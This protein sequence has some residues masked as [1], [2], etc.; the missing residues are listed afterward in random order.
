M[1][2]MNKCLKKGVAVF[3]K[4]E[5]I[6]TA[7]RALALRRNL[8]LPDSGD[9]LAIL[10]AASPRPPH[11]TL[12]SQRDWPAIPEVEV[13]IVVPCYNVADYVVE[14]VESILNQKTLRSYEVI[15][16]DDGSSDATGDLLD[17]LA[18]QD[19]RLRVVHQVNKGSSGARNVGISLA[20]G[21][22]V[23]FVDSDD[24]LELDAIEVLLSAYDAGDCDFVTANYSVMNYD[25]SK[26]TAPVGKRTHGAPWGRVYSR[27][28][29]RNIEFPVGFY[30]ED[31]VQAY[32]V[33]P[34]FKERY[35]EQTVCRYRKHEK[36][37]T[38]ISFSTKKGLDTFWVIDELLQWCR[39]LGIKI[40]QTIFDQ[41]LRQ[42]GWFM[43]GR[44]RSLDENERRAL[45]AA[46]CNLFESIPEFADLDT[47]LG[48]KWTDVLLA[49]RTHNY[50]LWILASLAA[51][52]C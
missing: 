36:S 3:L 51:K 9:A 16:V 8:I 11:C 35:I 2:T 7:A 15:A 41:T 12:P 5:S 39:E 1:T 25:G 50:H 19:A 52:F 30:Y 46:C 10:N 23:I 18:S 48:G 34:V 22:C 38:V 32:C 21:K 14:C 4:S 42:M 29:W 37:I 33:S 40:D 6:Y 24:V 49:L 47:T 43:L 26:V 31:T 44:T 20:R 17:E 27:E 13:S 28:V 45:F